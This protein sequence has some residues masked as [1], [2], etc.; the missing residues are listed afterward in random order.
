MTIT[1][2]TQWKLPIMYRF[3]LALYANPESVFVQ[4]EE[5]T[6]SGAQEDTETTRY[7][8][9]KTTDLM[10]YINRNATFN[11]VYVCAGVG[12]CVLLTAC[13]MKAAALLEI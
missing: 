11:C 1:R 13:R 12:G 4:K 9:A 3:L 10:Y 7:V 6:R 2:I 5:E 8:E